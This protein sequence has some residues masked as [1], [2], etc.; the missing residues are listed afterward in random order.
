[1]AP[2]VAE[3]AQVRRA[4]AAVGAERRRHLA[5]LLL[6]EAGLDDHLAGELHAGRGE[7]KLEVG[8][9]AKA[10]QAAVGVLD[11]AAEEEV[12]DA[13]EDGVADVAMQPGHGAGL[14]AT[15]EAVAHD[16]VVP[17]AELFDEGTE[18]GEVVG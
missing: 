12:E 13:G 4:V 14:D 3:A 10:A 16:Q 18:L 7:V 15:P 2:A 9:L 8:V 5:D 1:M 11:G 17:L 6:V